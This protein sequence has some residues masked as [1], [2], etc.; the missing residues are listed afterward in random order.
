MIFKAN[1]DLSTVFTHQ[2]MGEHKVQAAWISSESLD[3]RLGDYIV[4]GSEKFYLNRPCTIQKV[5]NFTYRYSAT[6][7]GEVYELYRKI[8]FD[9]GRKR[10][11]YFGS[12]EDFMLLILENLNE[13]NPGWTLNIDIPDSIIPQ[14]LSFDGDSCRVAMTKVME[15]FKLEFRLV[16]REIIIRQDVGFDSV[17]TFKYGRWEG[18]YSLIRESKDD[19]EV[20][21]RLYGF[22]GER[23][24]PASYRSGANELM[25][26]FEG[27]PYIEANVEIYGI[28]EGTVSFPDIFPRR[29]GA[30][31]GV[32]ANNVV[33]DSTLD[34]D[35][36]S[37]LL[38]GV[39]AKIVFKSGALS[40]YEF[41]IERYDHPTRQIRFIP[42]E[43]ANGAIIPDEGSFQPE[44]G[45]T[46]TLIGINMPQTYVEAAESELL[47]ATQEAHVKLK[48]PQV[49]YSLPLDEKYVR[50]NGIQLSCGM[51]VTIEDPDLGL[52]EKIRI[53]SISF[54]LVNPSLVT[55]QIADTI[56][57]TAEERI[58]RDVSTIKGQTVVID[59]SRV[60]NFRESSLRFRQLQD[61][62][63]DPDGYFDPV[64]IKPSTIETQMLSVGA[65]SQNFIL[66]GVEIAPNY[67]GDANSLLIS[68][69]EL[70]H[71]EIEIDGLGYVWEMDLRLIE[72]LETSKSYY[73]YAR[74]NRSAL[75]GTW[76]IS[77]E[78]INTDQETGFYHFWLGILYPVR[79]DI[80]FFHF[81][82]GMTYIVGDTITTGKIQSVDGKVYFDLSNA[83]FNVGSGNKGMDW[84]VTNEDALTIRGAVLVDAVFAD[85]GVIQNLRVNQLRTAESGKRMEIRAF[86]D[87]EQTIPAHNQKFYDD[88]GNLVMTIDTGIDGGFVAPSQVSAGILLERP[89]DNPRKVLMSQNGIVSEGSIMSHPTLGQRLGSVIGILRT[90]VF[91]AFG[92]AGAVVGWDAA[93]NPQVPSFGGLFNSLFASS[94][95]TE[96]I[97]YTNPGTYLVN[98]FMTWISCYNSSG[99]ITIVL[100]ALPKQGRT[101]YIKRVLS[102]NV[103]IQSNG[104]SMQSN[105]GPVNTS[106]LTTRG[107]TRRLQYDG[108]YW[109]M[110]T[111]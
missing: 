3:I 51:K 33:R 45:D 4:V 41:D 104:I 105:G 1:I 36:N 103:V 65:R 101:L 62:I 47:A 92:I 20:V 75:T 68:S 23:N 42:R 26:D 30:L 50:E 18:L 9:E 110:N 22:G 84:N 88:D 66:N 37:Q 61:K 10:F 72:G 11:S 59:R 77:E 58:I 79:N 96:S 74:C 71:L 35:I 82:R 80:R 107:H 83:K 52:N 111:L 49:S 21:T 57:Y 60:E 15:A 24:I 32:E 19:T 81:T 99:T 76:V 56:P 8:L 90:T 67:S 97:R 73:V 54:P 102:G 89:G 55:A 95:H 44:I 87:E 63:Y 6:F 109:Q 64:N 12:P 27:K 98:E 38:G 69:G 34:F 2:L 106:N 5:N 7:E 31:T 86:E 29:T 14:L 108:L 40:G 28:R 48:S 91:S 39:T 94:F 16:Q 100:P 46:Y 13:D 78:T 25:F 93:P 70:I 17:Y 43:E 85:N 53:Y